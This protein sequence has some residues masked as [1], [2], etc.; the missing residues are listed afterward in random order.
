MNPAGAEW[1]QAEAEPAEHE[2][3][4]YPGRAEA[5]HR[6]NARPDV[7]E[8]PERRQRALI[9]S[10]RCGNM[11]QKHTEAAIPRRASTAARREALAFW[12][13]C[14]QLSRDGRHLCIA[15]VTV[16]VASIPERSTNSYVA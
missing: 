4:R 5:K 8:R 6:R 9:E 3:Q 11:E 13:I 14:Y 10:H 15:A 2:E 7:P 12:F 1:L 16:V